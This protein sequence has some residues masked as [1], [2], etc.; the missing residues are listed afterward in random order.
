MQGQAI[1]RALGNYNYRLLLVGQAISQS[2][3]WMARI[4]QSWLVLEMTDSPVALG[5]VTTLQF[6]PILL[7]SLFAGALADRYPKRRVLLMVQS[8]S[9]A[10]AVTLAVLVASGQVP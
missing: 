1:R 7:L 3:G 10:Q 5:T 9:M 6:L 2:G 8:V 4:A